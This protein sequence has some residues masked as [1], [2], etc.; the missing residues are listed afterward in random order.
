MNVEGKVPVLLRLLGFLRPYRSRMVLGFLCLLLDVAFELAPG[1]VWLA[2]VDRVVVERHLDRLPFL[3]GLLIAINFGEALVSRARRLLI[4][5]TAQGL[6]RDVRNRMFDKLA[7][8]PLA[9]FGEAHTGDLL[10]RVGADVDAIQEVVVNGTDSLLANFLRLVGV[11]IIFVSLNPILGLATVSP[12]AFVGVMIF[13]FNRRVRPLYTAARKQLGTLNARLSD[14]LTG[15]RVVKGFARENEEKRAFGALNDLFVDTQ[16][17]A[18][19]ARANSFPWVGFVASF[20]NVVMIGLGAWLI[21]HGQFTLGGLIAYRNYGRYF[22]GP[23]DNLTQINDMVQRAIAAGTRVF[24]VL[25]APVSV[26]DK[27]NAIDLPPVEGHLEFRDV[28]FSYAPPPVFRDTRRIVPAIHDVDFAI[29]P[30]QRVALVGESGAGK[31]TLFALASRFYDPTEG[32]VLL[33]GHDLRDV[34]QA[35]LRR[36]IVSVQQDTF[37]FAATVAENIRYGRPGATDEEI[38][39]AAK[40]ANALEFIERLPEGFATLVGE[41]GVKLSGGQRQRISIARAFLA[42]GRLLLLDEATSAVEPESERLIYESLQRLLNGRTA[43]IAT[44]RLSTVR[45]A[46]LI[47]VIQRGRIVERGQHEDLMRLNGRY[48]SMVRDQESGDALIRTPVSLED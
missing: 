39:A 12:I 47:L 30:G 8:L 35:S 23:I 43:L 44:H 21:V 37:L 6:V 4:E 11:V 1:L 46:D 20:G 24:E 14:V 36:Q 40:A 38:V 45:G 3:V 26:A 13:F 17:R 15:I 28:D 9:Y 48:A 19:R 29:Q 31:S 22:Y 25:D 18:V 7:A 27:P 41:R 5:P 42:G 32:A 10:S 16:L 34:S 2:I 33:D